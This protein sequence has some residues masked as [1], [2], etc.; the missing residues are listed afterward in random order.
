MNCLE[1][2]RALGAEP[3]R[4][5]LEIEAHLAACP[6]CAAH[7]EELASFD[8]LLLRAL[9]VPVPATAARVPTGVPRRSWLAL[10]ASI[11]GAA[12]L[13]AG[14]WTF[15]PREALASAV[16]GHMAHEPE[17]WE[18]TKPV[19]ASELAYVLG[20]AGVQLAPD[21]PE[22]TYAMSCWFRGWH[23]PHLVV[24]TAN[25]PMTVMVLRHEKVTARQA[26][27]EGGY[28]G[29]IVPAGR[30]AFAVLAKTSATAADIDVVA[31]RLSRAVRFTD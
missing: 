10:A 20:R 26:F 2:R 17:S 1:L 25:G 24:H 6:G 15:Y 19:P 18:T 3:S 16:V 12:I 8:R 30:G 23:V 31:D 28:R 13:G 29:V 21:A 7:A 4:R 9:Q 11:F 14:L 27:D 22:V 5:T